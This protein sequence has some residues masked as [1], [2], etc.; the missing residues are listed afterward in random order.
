MENTYRAE[1]FQKF[2]RF[3]DLAK[4]VFKTNQEGDITDPADR[5]NFIKQT[6]PE[7]FFRLL[8]TANGLLIGGK[9]AKWRGEAVK[10]IV[11]GMGGSTPVVD[12]EPPDHAEQEFEKF[13]QQMRAEIA[14][15]NLALYS[16]KLYTAIILSHMFPDGNGRLARNFYSLLRT[17]NLLNEERSNKRGKDIAV[18]AVSISQ[19]AMLQVIHKDNISD[20]HNLFELEKEY[21]GVDYGDDPS[22]LGFAK[23]MKYVAARRVLVNHS[24]FDTDQKIIRIDQWPSDLHH[25]YEDAY[26]QVRQ[27]CFWE[28]LTAVD[29]Y[30]EWC[31]ATLDKALIAAA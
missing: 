23:Q 3:V 29:R 26:Q 25:E 5:V 19:E 27:Q 7:D 13:Y 20:N 6:S 14:S 8:S 10:S 16:A 22:I 30:S 24:Q 11:M 18:Y 9:T 4:A 31:I 1:N 15:E 17:G 21:I 2:N 12:F 28:G